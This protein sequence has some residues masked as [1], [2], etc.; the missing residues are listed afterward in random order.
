LCL[1]PQA[2]VAV[3]EAAP[4]PAPQAMVVSVW[5]SMAR[6]RE[7]WFSDNYRQVAALR[8]GTGEFHVGA[9]AGRSDIAISG[10]QICISLADT[11]P[12]EADILASGALLQLEG[13]MPSA[14]ELSCL[15]SLP[16][17]LPGSGTWLFAPRLPLSTFSP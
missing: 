3:P 10:A 1:S 11:A 8:A 14:G 15:Q 9:L 16:K 6:L 17:A 12:I 2:T 13:A 7:F 5:A 4:V